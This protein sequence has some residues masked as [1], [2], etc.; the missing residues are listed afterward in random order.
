M[1][2]LNEDALSSDP[3]GASHEDKDPSG[4][5]R[6]ATEA[7]Q[8]ISSRGIKTPGIQVADASGGM[9]WREQLGALQKSAPAASPVASSPLEPSGAGWRD[10]LRALEAPTAPEQGNFSRGFEVSGKQLKQTAYGTA[11]L[12][13]D[14]VGSN[15]LKDWGLKG[16]QEAAKEVQKISKETDSFSTAFEQGEMGKWLSYSSGYLIGQVAEMGAASIAGA[17]AG[18][19]AAP[20]AGSV[21]GALAGA[22]EKG[23]VQAGVKSFVGKMIDKQ[24]AANVAR[25]MAEEAATSA[26]IKSVY[27]KIGATTANTFLNATQELGSIYGDAVE[28]A[29]LTGKEYSLGKVWLSGVAAT[30]VDSWADS[31][32]VGKFMD[33]IGG[34]KDIKGVALEALKGGFREGMTEG[35]QTAIERWGANKDLTSKEAFR[36]YIDSAAVGILGGGVAGGTSGA[37]N[38]ITSG[39]DKGDKGGP[40]PGESSDVTQDTADKNQP[41]ISAPVGIEKQELLRTMKNMDAMAY[42]YD[43]GDEE[44]KASIERAV[45]RAGLIAEFDQAKGNLDAI[46]T[47][48]SQLATE[49]LF[50]ETLRNALDTFGK[51]QPTDGKV[52]FAPRDNTPPPSQFDQADDQAI[53]DMAPADTNKAAVVSK[54]AVPVVENANEDLAIIEPENTE[55]AQTTEAAPAPAPV[56]TPAQPSAEYLEAKQKFKDAAAQALDIA[57][58]S[59]GAKLNITGKQY[60]AKDLPKAIQRVM[61]ALVEMGYYKLRDISTQVMLR[62]RANDNWK[63]LADQVTPFMLRQA[64]KK[65]APFENKEADK[66]VDGF[67]AKELYDIITYKPDN[68]QTPMPSEMGKAIGAMK[69]A[70]AETTIDSAIDEAG[71]KGLSND[72]IEYDK[73]VAKPEK[74]KR[75]AISVGKITPVI[76][77]HLSTLSQADQKE[78]MLTLGGKTDEELKRFEEQLVASK[79][80]KQQREAEAQRGKTG[81]L[82]VSVEKTEIPDL[83]T[84]RQKIDSILNMRAETQFF[85][86]TLAKMQAAIDAIDATLRGNK[87]IEED[88][89]KFEAVNESDENAYLWEAFGTAKDLPQDKLLALRRKLVDEIRDMQ[90]KSISG[91][92]QL[93]KSSMKRIEYELSIARTKALQAGM[94]MAAVDSVYEP[95]RN[96]VIAMMREMKGKNKEQQVVPEQYKDKIFD[97]IQEDFLAKEKTV[98]QLIQDLKDGK[99]N[100]VDAFSFAAKAIREGLF[101]EGELRQEMRRQGIDMP[102]QMIGVTSQVAM[103]TRML[104]HVKANDYK[105]MFRDAWLRSMD[106]IVR[107]FPRTLDNE[108]FTDGEKLAYEEWKENRETLQA[109]RK[110]DEVMQYSN[111]VN[112]AFKGLLF[113]DFTLGRMRNTDTIPPRTLG[114]LKDSVGDLP[115]AWF[116]DVAFALHTRPDLRNQITEMIRPEEMAEFKQ[117]VQ[118]KEDQVNTAAEVTAML[119]YYQQLANLDALPDEVYE[120]VRK[121]IARGHILQL[122]QIMANA[123]RLNDAIGGRNLSEK[124]LEFLLADYMEQV[125]AEED[126]NGQSIEQ[127]FGMDEGGR[128]AI[129]TREESVED[130]ANSDEG[131]DFNE[132]DQTGA[133]DDRFKRGF[134][135]G[136]LT[137]AQ[138]QT[139]IARITSK[140]KNAPQIT[141]LQNAT[142]LPEPL[143]TRVMERLG[144]NMGAKGVFDSET[145]HVY[146]FSDMLSGEAD[147][148]FVLFHEVYGHMGLRAFLGTKFD[149]FLKNMY[150]AYP[151]IKAEVDALVESEGLPL[152]EAI[153]EVISDFAGKGQQI[154]AVKAWVG[155]II[156]GLRERGFG[157]VADW[158]AKLTNAELAYYLKGAQEAAQNGGYNVMDGAPG[159]IRLAEERLPY[160][161]FSLKGDTT[162]AYS[163][164]NPVT[165]TWAVFKA[166]GEDIRNGYTAVV[167]DKYED[168]LEFMRKA[169]YVERRKRSGVFVDDKLPGDMPKMAAATD[170]TGM[171]RWM[172]DLITRYQNEYKPVFDVVD[173]LRGQG[174][175]TDRMDVKTALLLYER[176]TGAVVEHFRR[177]FVEPLMK[178]VGEAKEQGADYDLINRFLLARH[179]EERNKQ[180][181]RVNPK[182]QDGGS[183]MTTAEA[184]AFL[185]SLENNP[186][187]DTLQEIG[188]MTDKMSEQKL[189]Y[190]VNTGMITIKQANAMRAA[191]KSYVNLSGLKEGLDGFDDPSRLAGGSKFNVKGKEQRA[192]GRESEATDI[193]GRT[194]LGMEAALI[195]GQKNLVAQ[196]VLA[197]VEAN[198]DPNFAVVN[199]IAYKKVIGEDGMVTEQ[200]DPEYIRRKDVMV[201]KI[202]GIP[203]TI[204][205]K[206]TERGSFADAIHGMV[207]PPDSS[208]WLARLGKFNQVIGQMLTTWNPAWVAVNFARDVQ[209]MYFNAASD[210]RITKA[211]AAQMVKALP[212]AIKTALYMASNGKLNINVDPEMV[213]IY[214]EMKRAGGLTSFLN[215]KDLE[216]QVAEIHQMLGERSKL[217]KVG[218]RFKGVLDLMEYM[219]LP[220]EIA[221]RLAAYKV[222]RDNGFTADQAAVFSGEI[223]VNFNM[224]GSVKEMRQLFL[225]F[226]PAVQ[227]SAKMVS[228]ARNNPGRLTGYAFAFAGLGAM[229]N[230]IA[231]AAG[232]DDEAGRNDLDKVPTYKRATSLVIKPN[233]PGGAIPIPYGWN[234][235]YA[236]GH[237][238]MDS[239]LGVQ[240]LDVTAKR[241]AKTAFEA[242]TPLGTAGLD[243]KSIVGTVLKGVSPTATLP[244]VEWVMNENRYGA[245]IRKE[246]DQFGGAVLPDSQMAFRSVSPISK[247]IA[248]GLNEVTGGNKYKAGAID[249]N[250]AAIDFIIGSYAPGL[251]NEVYKG[252]STAARVARGE[253]VKNTPMPL[254]DRFTA[255]TPDGFDAGAFRRAKELI[256]T[257]FNEYK[258]MPELRDDIRKEVPGLMRAHAVVAATTQEI[259][260][261][262]AKLAK[263][264]KNE[265]I[266]E[267]EKVDRLNR[268]RERET[269]LYNRAVKAVMDAGPEFKQAVMAAD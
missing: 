80:Q 143:R 5:Y 230:L 38:K 50:V 238:M 199:E 21:A 149:S 226:N 205:F 24:V 250:P 154:P 9:S 52:K 268:T 177:N 40:A 172:R 164:F 28:E 202:N 162:A 240:P 14:T 104:D 135:S 197:L 22:V 60:T 144:A 255:K 129:D 108:T 180:I 176:K 232:D 88:G 114:A 131:F 156:A 51:T 103:Q 19:F 87:V 116:Q 196:R 153:D 163:R 256:E 13:G 231:R 113:V 155:K 27:G 175:L 12:I 262:R 186:A 90:S 138:V 254:V 191:Y 82:E 2:L 54:A 218:D 223:T 17:V 127:F 132:E 222:V 6:S 16:Y 252:A 8:D 107:A 124:D 68:K 206:D 25:G 171:K 45:Q 173:Y 224:R 99:I 3:L 91:Q 75:Q 78:A 245:P 84:F 44:Q 32:A 95:A 257:R 64:Y 58:D 146:M 192:M 244:I 189:K 115:E 122:D 49:P 55:V 212:S 11:A 70:Q 159:V 140:W 170:V 225:F 259:R 112:E 133:L 237:F 65:I 141:V 136:V 36:E 120:R 86:D 20:G 233:M 242:Y 187:F 117:W 18:S 111:D 241:I 251:V 71:D 85:R 267:A 258:N 53:V 35:V 248:E 269:A 72:E 34:S 160:E 174:R 67:K 236:F 243:S 234:A 142:M 46:R 39:E 126:I 1:S 161:L 147:T 211:Q 89:K 102:H 166:T 181:A 179:A 98:L 158:M 81:E 125:Q 215:R 118:K 220:M 105:P 106:T 66:D 77:E 76:R 235:F 41:Q 59:S 209:T 214:N 152:L 265:N 47:G 69:G 167:M 213:R 29:A 221:P 266:S 168:V 150:N 190:Q 253:D 33:S 97:A 94:D 204:R 92:A 157:R 83:K 61:E 228:L 101:T 184:K 31:K 195:R 130:L 4:L 263:L 216:E 210:G 185:K 7:F 23:A 165:Q 194:I 207:Y 110:I 62:M 134:F 247:S 183:G 239:I 79:Q 37:L 217:Q 96:S 56:A 10:Q 169:G 203:A 219:T 42:L 43:S 63:D 137:A 57:M 121:E 74:P 261:V 73:Y 246:G 198:Y 188:R 123:K 193:L 229:A 178:L 249:V 200:E 139:T 100:D 30:A 145:G 15:S 182:M 201:A 26:A 119:P 48:E 148:E 93:F 109:R 227:G 260:D 264:E 208:P 151:R 128:Q